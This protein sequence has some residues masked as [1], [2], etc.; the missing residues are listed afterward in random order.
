MNNWFDSWGRVSVADID[1]SN[2]VS[3]TESCLSFYG[4]IIKKMVGRKAP[5]TWQNTYHPLEIAITGVE[6]FGSALDFLS[7][8]NK[9]KAKDPALLLAKEKIAAFFSQTYFNRKISL[10]LH[11]LKKNAK[12]SNIKKQ[13]LDNTLMSYNESFY[14]DKKKKRIQDI[15][16]QLE[17]YEGEFLNNMRSAKKNLY[18]LV[19]NSKGLESIPAFIKQ[20]AIETSK[21]MN[22]KAKYA[23]SLEDDTYLTLMTHCSSRATRKYIYQ[24]RVSLA[25][26]QTINNDQALK[27]LIFWRNEKAK[28][29]GYDNYTDYATSFSGLGNSK[30]VSEFLDNMKD[31]L[32]P[33]YQEYEELFKK[34]AKNKLGFQKIYPWDRAYIKGHMNNA[35]NEQ[36]KIK[37]IKIDYFKAQEKMFSIA[38]EMF[39]LE[40]EI[41]TQVN[42]WDDKISCYKV[43]NKEGHVLSHLYFDV[44][45]RD[46][47]PANLIYQYTIN[48]TQYINKEYQPSQQA[49]VMHL[50]A[51]EQ[52]KISITL[53]DMVTLFHE[54]GHALHLLL[55]KTQYHQQ[56]PFTIEYDAIEFPSQ[57]FEK[58]ALCPDLIQSIAYQKNRK[59]SKKKA[60]NLIESTTLHR[61]YQYWI[62]I[63]HSQI[64]IHLNTH[65]KPNGSK[66]FHEA[67]API[68]INH[69]QKLAKYNQFQ[70]NQF[71]HFYMGSIYYG[72]LWAE[73][74]VQLFDS[75][76]ESSS[77]E[78]RGQKIHYL[79]NKAV[80]K[81][82]NEELTKMVKVPYGS[83]LKFKMNNALIQGLL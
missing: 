44:F 38:K 15:N 47:K 53:D 65:F 66:T 8:I 80:E 14:A 26:N 72:Y 22:F 40:F 82:F 4:T 78:N 75:K 33:C 60:I 68:F 45:K 13:I 71:E 7:G 23:F 46:E 73:H 6:N 58:F 11:E 56:D 30:T 19:Q 76:F 62:H 69:N 17:H 67:L 36:N 70:N 52:G 37:D 57:W 20:K 77:L 12:L 10:K 50:N 29:N 54:F 83:E 32:Q 64:D 81:P 55:T 3:H 74:M 43:T 61:S 25:S 79:L 51:D 42:V 63:M 5:Y 34:Y 39:G 49:V 9:I 41:E 31:H 2:V 1:E 16:R 18:I 59:I 21:K 35:F 27:K 24:C 48:P 28:I